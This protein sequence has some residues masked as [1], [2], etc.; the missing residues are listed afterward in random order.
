MLAIGFII[1]LAVSMA[2][3]DTDG[4]DPRYVCLYEHEYPYNEMCKQ[5]RLDDII[6]RW[7][8]TQ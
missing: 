5:Q 2:Y 3:G 8:F 6:S 1:A 7:N 4:I